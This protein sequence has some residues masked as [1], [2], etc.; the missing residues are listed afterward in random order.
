MNAKKSLGQNFFNNQG[1][2]QKIVDIVLKED[3][4]K[5]LEIGPGRGAFTSLFEKSGV[6]LE[7]VEKDFELMGFLSNE[8]QSANIINGDFLDIDL[9]Q[10]E[11]DTVYSSLPYNVSKPIIEKILKS[12]KFKRAVFIIQLEVAQDYVEHGGRFTR[13]AALSQ[14][15]ADAKLHFKIAP[16]NFRP[17]PK[18]NSAL[19]EFTIKDKQDYQDKV[20]FDKYK[21]LVFEVFKKSNK[22]IKNN[23]GFDTSFNDKRAREL[24]F[25]D[26]LE[27]Y[28]EMYL[29]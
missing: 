14:F 11:A 17:I 29:K 4:K 8:F 25:E 13:L 27:I 2:A 12:G 9:D 19:I 18:V 20:S 21:K 16:G 1:L 10:I 22:K 26:I 23:I 24:C 6:E 3:S 7:L 15:Y 28:S 5:I